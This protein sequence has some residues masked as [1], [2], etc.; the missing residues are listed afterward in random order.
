MQVAVA[1]VSTSTGRDVTAEEADPWRRSWGDNQVA[2]VV[3][4]FT[5]DQNTYS[6][7]CVE[8]CKPCTVMQ[9]LVAFN[10]QCLQCARG[11]DEQIHS[12][13]GACRPQNYRT[14][15]E[16]CPD[17]VSLADAKSMQYQHWM[18]GHRLVHH[19][20]S[21]CKTE[22]ELRNCSAFILPASPPPFPPAHPP[23]H[24]AAT[25]ANASPRPP[26]HPHCSSTAPPTH[27][28]PSLSLAPGT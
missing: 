22:S 10:S 18:L 13:A 23:P 17:F 26:S 15:I 21:F 16:P 24:P 28:K 6:E 11:P 14:E 4:H 2:Q 19:A 1:A 7:P 8:M 3:N 27:P 9:Y 20:T 25:S 5:R 12:S